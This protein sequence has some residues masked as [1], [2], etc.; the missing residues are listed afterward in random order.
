MEMLYK[1]TMQKIT[2]GEE[3]KQKIINTAALSARKEQSADCAAVLKA[4]KHKL[5]L[6]Q[7]IPAMV[8]AAAIICCLI[9]SV[10]FSAGSGMSKEK[11]IYVLNKVSEDIRKPVSMNNIDLSTPQT[12]FLEEFDELFEDGFVL[13][14]DYY[15]FRDFEMIVGLA[16]HLLDS[17]NFRQNIW[18][19][20][21]IFI[22]IMSGGFSDDFTKLY[23]CLSSTEGS[24]ILRAYNELQDLYNEIIIDYDF[25]R[26]DYILSSK[27]TSTKLIENRF[28]YQ[29][30]Y[31]EKKGGKFVNIIQ[32]NIRTDRRVK[33]PDENFGG[34]VGAYLFGYNSAGRG[35]MSIYF[36]NIYREPEKAQRLAEI[37]ISSCGVSFDAQDEFLGSQAS[38]VKNSQIKDYIYDFYEQYLN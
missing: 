4:K 25:K 1:D 29:F 8:T 26:D 3:L 27:G 5:K 36:E 9:V 18:Y 19:Y 34:L 33:P 16:R 14:Q 2:A 11:M 37:I 32:S 22:P 28:Y 23:M 17:P 13:S 35:Y 38:A 7:V 15:I 10:I 30:V 12:N 6:R 20:D 24:I 21:E 31:A